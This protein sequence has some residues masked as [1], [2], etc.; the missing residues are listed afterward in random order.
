MWLF[1]ST[2]KL[3]HSCEIVPDYLGGL[4]LAVWRDIHKGLANVGEILRKML[5]RFVSQNAW[6]GAAPIDL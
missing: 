1:H 4:I 3:F 5:E 6:G 2:N